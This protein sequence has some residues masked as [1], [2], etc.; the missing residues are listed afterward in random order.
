MFIKNLI[1]DKS[2]TR[3]KMLLFVLYCLGPS[4]LFITCTSLRL[5]EGS[6]CIRYYYMCD[7]INKYYNINVRY[8]FLVNSEVFDFSDSLHAEVVVN[9][10][11]GGQISLQFT[12]YP[13][14]LFDELLQ[15]DALFRWLYDKV[16]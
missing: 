13:T 3:K 1:S 8:Y 6:I 2:K 15:A 4:Q 14:L 12:L 9:A 10:P 11:P 16:E 5:L 7:S